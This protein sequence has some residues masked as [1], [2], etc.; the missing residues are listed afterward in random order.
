MYIGVIIGALLAFEVVRTS[1]SGQL[2]QLLLEGQS[3]WPLVGVI[4]LALVVASLGA[5]RAGRAVAACLAVAFS[6]PLSIR[7]PPTLKRPC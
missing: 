4:G 3:P 6:S 7:T 1:G 2:T 5:P